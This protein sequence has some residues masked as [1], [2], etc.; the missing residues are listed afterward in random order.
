MDDLAGIEGAMIVIAVSLAVQTIVLVAGA[1]WGLVTYRRLSIQVE[2]EMAALKTTLDDVSR[3]VQRAAD[4]VGRST[5]AVGSAVD[6]A[7]QA[8]QTLGKWTGTATTVLR[9]PRAAAVVGVIRGWQ[10]WRA[11]RARRRLNDAIDIDPA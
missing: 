11:R 9:A 1:V 5:D 7:R 2:R 3:T 8:A 10:W 6:E 4:A